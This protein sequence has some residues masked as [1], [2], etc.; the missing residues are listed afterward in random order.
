[1]APRRFYRQWARSLYCYPVKNRRLEERLESWQEGRH[2]D[3][4]YEGHT[5]KDNCGGD[6]RKDIRRVTEVYS[7]EQEHQRDAQSS[8]DSSD[9]H[10]HPEGVGREG[11]LLD[12][13]G[14]DS[15]SC[16]DNKQD[17]FVAHL[18]ENHPVTQTSRIAR[19]F[20]VGDA[21]R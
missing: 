18:H 8:N 19:V 5:E 14:Q 7:V 12:V 16:D 2:E 20:L 13:P 17:G 21:A 6:D 1:M 15:Q 4:A 10:K 3:A 11:K 9:V